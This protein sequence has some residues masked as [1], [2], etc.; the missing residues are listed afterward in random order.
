MAEH[1]NR[2]LRAA[3]RWRRQPK[4]RPRAL[5]NAALRLLKRH[6]YRKIRVEDVAEAA[7]LSKTAVYHYFPNKDELLRQTLATRIAERTAEIERLLESAGGPP[8]KRLRKF[9]RHF[10][11]MSL[12]SQSGLWQRLLITELAADAP[13]LFEIWAQGLVDRWT[14]VEALIKEGQTRGEFRRDVDAPV[15]ARLIVSGLAHQALF[16]V[17]LGVSRLAPC[18]PDHLFETAVD[19]LFQTLRARGR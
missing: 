11:D 16:H 10:W 7:G 13:E 19:H 3:P 18:D 15:A 6:G 1:L 12:T 4:Q 8:S 17:H 5:M 2:S 9:L 14:L